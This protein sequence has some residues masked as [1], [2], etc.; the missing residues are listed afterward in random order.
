MI[1]ANASRLHYAVA[2]FT[3]GGRGFNT[4]MYGQQIRLRHKELK[5]VRIEHYLSVKYP[6]PII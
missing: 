3:K 5:P 4:N 1:I 6:R 2:D